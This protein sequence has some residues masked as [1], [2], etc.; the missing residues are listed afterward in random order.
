MNE[1]LDI[2]LGRAWIVILIIVG[3]LLDRILVQRLQKRL[4]LMVWG[5]FVFDSVKL[6]NE[7]IVTL[8]LVSRLYAK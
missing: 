2:L 8:L 5:V 4:R 3:L 1:C 6:A 7:I